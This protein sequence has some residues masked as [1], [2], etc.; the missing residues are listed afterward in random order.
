MVV[1]GFISP[2]QKKQVMFIPL[3]SF[4]L[5]GLPNVC[6]QDIALIQASL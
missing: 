1:L 6:Q 4:A 5:D 2:L 3:S